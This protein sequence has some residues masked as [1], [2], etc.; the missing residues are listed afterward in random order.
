[1]LAE[2]APTD[3]YDCPLN[4]CCSQYGFCG[5]TSDFCGTGCITGCDEVV[6]PDA[7]VIGYYSS[8]AYTRTCNAWT[9]E[10]IDAGL[11]THLIYAFATIGSDYKIGMANSFDSELYPRFTALK[12][13]AAGLSTMM[14]VGGW[15]EGG[16]IFSDMVST[17]E[18]RST[19]IDSVMA[20]MSTYGFD[21]VDIDWEYPAASDRGGVAADTQ[22]YVS[23]LK[24]MKAA[25]GSVY[26]VTA[27]LPS[28]YWYLQGFDVSGMEPYVDWF[29]F[30]SYDIHGTWDGN[31]PY[32]EAVVQPHTNLTEIKE[33]LDLLWRND[34]DPSKVVLGEAFYGRSFTLS[35][36]SCTSPGCPF[37]GGGIPGE[38]TDTAGIL[39]DAEIQNVISENNLTPILEETAAVK[40]IVWDDNQW[41]SYDDAETLDL[42]RTFANS[43]CLGGRFVWSVDLDNA[44]SKE[45]LVDLSTS[46][47]KLLG[48]DVS[49]NPSYA[50]DKLSAISSQNSVNL[51]SYWTACSAAPQCNAGYSQ[52]TL[53]HG[54]VYDADKGIYTADGCH[55]GGN[56]Y[57][58]ALC[59]EADV[60]GVNCKWYGKP[61]GCSQTCP[62]GTILLAQNTHVGGAKS[63]CKSGHFS[64]YCCESITTNIIDDCPQSNANSIFTGGQGIIRK[65]A[66]SVQ[67]YKDDSSLS[68][69]TECLFPLAAFT[70]FVLG[71]GYIMNSIPGQWSSSGLFTP[72]SNRAYPAA[73]VARPCTETVTIHTTV[74]SVTSSPSTVT[75]DGDKYPQACAHYSS[76]SYWNRYS[77]LRCPVDKMSKR[78]LPD[79]WSKEHL[80]S[81]LLWVPPFAKSLGVDKC[82][83]DEYPP[84]AFMESTGTTYT[85][86]LRF[87]PE[88]QNKGAGQL[89]KNICNDFKKETKLEGGPITSSTCTEIKSTVYTVNAM[90][91][92]FTNMPYDDLLADNP[93]LPEITHDYGFALM[94]NDR[95][96]GV[97]YLQGHDSAAYAMDPEAAL[98]QGLKPPRKK[99]AKRSLGY[100][101]DEPISFDFNPEDIILDEGN[102]SRRVTPEELYELGLLKC[103][104]DNCVKE[105]EALEI[106]YDEQDDAKIDMPLL[107]TT[108]ESASTTSGLPTDSRNSARAAYPVETG[109][110]SSHLKHGRRHSN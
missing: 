17:T 10:D 54:K 91:M 47:L 29:H 64:S 87:V 19:F 8:S 45:A 61:G 34:I 7:R 33:G 59:V 52:W 68:T 105:R 30:M 39:S 38:C 109:K 16:T 107:A 67:L 80:R 92:H 28:S 15:D 83:R 70:L 6:E 85:Q 46:G 3:S 66:S 25:F 69:L 43:K 14:S 95:W 56:G 18:R 44:T 75:C 71:A 73:A 42:K 65:D 79:V 110:S 100:G 13:S 106:P 21:G 58:R 108:S 31:N 76:V 88:S 50:L 23:L 103:E 77:T 5:T 93:C 36:S 78:K 27:T 41:V 99:P 81:W 63:G 60:T 37:S 32:T 82:N 97:N 35:K 102:S 12:Q 26:T 24:E 94:T 104:S 40:Y 86:W 72:Q 57:N 74:T 51:Y 89:W 98:T 20:F 53:G 62:S 96:Y 90:V 1:M 101:I 9:P 48:D 11:W 4:V 22:N 84:L 2:Y 49:S 55:G